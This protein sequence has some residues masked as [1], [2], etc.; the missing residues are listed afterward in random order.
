MRVPLSWLKEYVEI[1]LP[2][3]ELAERLTLAGL[4]VADIEKIGLPDAA[5]PWDPERIL[6]GEILE[7]RPHPDADRLVLA[8]VEYGGGRPKTV[9]TGA[10]NLRVGD[11]GHK[12]A[13]A[14]EG[15]RHWDGSSA[16]REVATLKGR[17]VRGV[18][19]D[20][21]VLSE[22]ELGLSDDHTGVLVLDSQAPV[23]TPLAEYMGDVVLD[24][25]ITPNMARCLSILGVAREVAGLTGGRVHIPPARMRADGEPVEG[26][27]AVA[28][29][30]PALCARYATTLLTGVTIGPSPE[31][32]RRR[33]RLAGIRPINNVVD[34][35]NYVMLEWGQ[36]LHAFD[37][38]VLGRRARGVPRITV[39]PAT[40]GEILTTLDGVTRAL[41]PERLLITDTAGPIAIAGVMG[42]AETEVTGATTTILLEAANF[43]FISIRKTAQA[44]KLPSEASARF[45]RGVP[46]SAA[47]PAAMR[48]TELMREL[49][50]GTIARGVADCYPAPQIPSVVTLTTE[51][52]R[53]ILGMDLPRAEVQRILTALEF[54]CDPQGETGL[55]V[56]APDHRLDIGTGVVGAADLIEEVARIHG[57]DRIPVTDMADRLPPQ[58]DAAAVDPEERVRDLLAIAGLQEVITYRL[59]TPERETALVPGNGQV[60]P[61]PYVTL[62][63]PISADRVVMRQTL[64]AGLLEVLAQ[65]LRLRERLR[66]F[67]IGPV[68]LPG[69]GNELPAEP[70]RLAIGMAGRITPASWRDPD[71]CRTDFFDLKGVVETFLQGLHLRAVG[72]EPATHPTFAPGRTARVLVDGEPVGVLG[73]IHPGVRAAFDL[74][75]APICLAELDLDAL[76]ARVPLTYRVAAVPRF[77][78]A[79]QDIA[80]VVDEDVPAAELTGTIRAAG[81]SLL[82]EARLFDV[83]RGRQLPR[84]KKSLAFSLVFQAVDRTLTDAE[85]EAE[86][87]RIVEAVAQRLGAELRV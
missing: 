31:W 75:A 57:Y 69:S 59:T 19:S 32:M 3:P 65:N 63:N 44:L 82:V 56:T 17:K 28:I 47:V 51:E 49:A 67:E 76:L 14:L 6:V 71:P 23:G 26:R 43:H 46:P 86:K 29:A 58:R 34:V 7:I 70:R 53:R 40:A 62:A 54:L 42:G 48:A 10:P 22:M 87:G 27:V 38:D 68:F 9:V 60:S 30:D 1:P 64:L 4:E 24:L 79:L 73:E 33:L 55:R 74:P 85:V 18:P 72:F 66:F 12:V 50:G 83:Y 61:R 21:M 36:P 45:G 15:A 41:T 77:P 5:L 52:V 35:T 13:F 2:V 25:E 20:G 8:T 80:L 16:A 11:K 84:G 81:G 39:R 37:Y 78:P